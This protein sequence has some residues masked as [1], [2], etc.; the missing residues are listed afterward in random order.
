MFFTHA[1]FIGIDPTAG[2][3]P[4]T[5]AALD[6]DLRLLALGQGEIDEVL[7]FAAGQ[8][9]AIAAVC[10]PRRPS[11]GVLDR[12]EVRQQLAVPPR[13]GRWNGYRLADYLL[14]QH[15]IPCPK[16]PASVSACP[17]WMRMGFS[18]YRKLENAGYSS[19]PTEG[20]A[21]Q[22]LEVYPHAAYTALLGVHPFPKHSLEG[23]IQR[24]LALFDQKVRVP[25]AMDFFEEIT[26]HR[27]LQ[28]ILPT[29]DLYTPVELDAL[30]A[31][32]TAWQ[33]VLHPERTL[34]L[35]DPEEG[36][37]VFPVAELKRRY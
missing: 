30:L 18:L 12:P 14:R 37:I 15:N 32:F 36:Q 4:F 6:D 26:R 3:R 24:Q 9:Q 5:Y 23:R 11:T 19:Y 29:K 28:G 35:G 13:P 25:D 22:M 7:A 16:T 10:A 33:A 20:A 27:L 17:G 21:L 34:S 31:A 1:T 2:Q 8:R